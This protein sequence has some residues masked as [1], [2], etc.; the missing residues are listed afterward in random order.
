MAASKHTGKVSISFE[1]LAGVSV[2]PLQQKHSL[3]K[4][5]D[6]EKPG[7]GSDEHGNQ[8]EEAE[9]DAADELVPPISL[10]GGI[11]EGFHAPQNSG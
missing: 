5:E 7:R 3:F 2:V 8:D 6:E 9:Q 1:D 11:V 10:P 4:A